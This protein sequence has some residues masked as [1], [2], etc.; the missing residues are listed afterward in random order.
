MIC[1]LNETQ[2]SDLYKITYKT[3]SDLKP[4]ESF[5]LKGFIKDIYNRVEKA[6]GEEKALQYAQII[7]NIVDVCKSNRDDINDKLV[8]SKFNFTSLSETRRDFK[9]LDNVKKYAT[10]FVR[11]KN[12]KELQAELEHENFQ[13][14]NVLITDADDSVLEKMQKAKIE[15]PNV[16]TFQFADEKNPS[17][18]E[19]QDEIDTVSKDKKV[20]EIVLKKIVKSVRELTAEEN[21]PSID[22][23]EIFLTVMSAKSFSD[24]HKLA[25]HKGAENKSSNGVYA[26]ITDADGNYL[27]FDEKGNLTD[28]DKGTVV[29]QFT[30]RPYL[31]EDKLN[32]NKPFV[33]FTIYHKLGKMY[34]NTLVAAAKVAKRM[35]LSSASE[36]FKQQTENMNGLYNMRKDII[37][38]DTSYTIQINGG[39]FGVLN[40]S[41]KKKLNTILTKLNNYI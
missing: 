25:I 29:Y 30:R 23:T 33:L 28:D 10:T 20:F 31:L 36:I 12:K 40:D 34:K 39:S 37:D 26:V 16:T 19:T 13:L 41:N 14:D 5:D 24:T 9:D 17:K 38:N 35:G 21:N 2:I 22:G 1:S 3:L 6:A 8:D 7:P 32:K 11:K 18:Q 15:F 4:S 27:Y